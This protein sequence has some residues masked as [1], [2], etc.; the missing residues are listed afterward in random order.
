[1]SLSIYLKPK[2]HLY[3]FMNIRVHLVIVFETSPQILRH[4]APRHIVGIK[5]FRSAVGLIG[6]A[7]LPFQGRKNDSTPSR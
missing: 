6:R 4:P 1:M 5:V 2:W 7:Q 3:L